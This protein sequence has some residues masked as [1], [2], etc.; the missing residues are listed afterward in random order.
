MIVMVLFIP[1]PSASRLEMSSEYSMYQS[2]AFPAYIGFSS[3]SE[4]LC[5]SI[6]PGLKR[7]SLDKL[8]ELS[9]VIFDGKFSA[10]DV[11]NLEKGGRSREENLNEVY[12]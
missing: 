2:P 4:F 6:S 10:L 8:I 9:I 5:N 12:C 1:T 11:T 3:R 7:G